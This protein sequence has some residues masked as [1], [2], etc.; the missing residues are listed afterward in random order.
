VTAEECFECE[1]GLPLIIVLGTGFT[2]LLIEQVID[3]LD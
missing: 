3:L 1:R 2:V